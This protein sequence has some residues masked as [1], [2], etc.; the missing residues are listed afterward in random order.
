[1]NHI[2]VMIMMM[3]LNVVYAMC[4]IRFDVVCDAVDVGRRRVYLD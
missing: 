2:I 4:I 3:M 1:M